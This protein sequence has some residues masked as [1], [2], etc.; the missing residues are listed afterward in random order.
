MKRNILLLLIML[1]LFAACEIKEFALPKWDV[2]VR[3]PL[4][5]QRFYVSELADEVNIIIS[6]DEVLTLVADGEMDTPEVGSVAL[7]PSVVLSDAPILSGDPA[8]MDLPIWDAAIDD[9]LYYGKIERGNFKYQ[10]NPIDPSA[11]ISLEFL[12][13]TDD[14]GENLRVELSG[15]SGWQNVNLAGYHFGDE[16]DNTE[17][18]NIEL[19]IVNSSDLPEGS[20]VATININLTEPL[21][22]SEFHGLLSDHELIM[23][24]SISA[25]ELQ[26]PLNIDQAVTL[27]VASLIID[28]ENRLGFRCEFEGEF[29]AIADG[30][31]DRIPIK[32]NNG[33]NFCIDPA[34]ADSP[35]ITRLVVENGL[36]NILQNMPTSIKL[37]NAKFTIST[38]GGLGFLHA[39]DYLSARYSIS[40][41]FTFILSDTPIT[42]NES[43]HLEISEDNQDIFNKRVSDS[44]MDFEIINRLPI[45]GRVEAYFSTIDEIDP[46]DPATF[47][48]AK[49]V[50]IKSSL[51]TNGGEP[52]FIPLELEEGE[53]R[54]FSNPEVFLKWRFAFE[55]SQ[56][57][58]I[59][60]Q[61]G[62]MD[63]IELRSMVS[64]KIMIGE[65]KK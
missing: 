32:D 27:Q 22:F 44:K 25:I 2:E 51:L 16:A 3:V 11:A 38:A 53:L 52:Q 8:N 34:E 57:Q 45:G 36:S 48:F 40:A 33:N 39:N 59:T 7:M 6:D 50:V 35:T 28:V 5:Y 21:Q 55:D 17:L 58:A 62:D 14:A 41:P 12:N 15:A 64:A 61:A 43:L 19:R 60:I 23:N 24:E 56:G 1:A 42:I 65:G 10:L 26:Y 31:E 37:D 9:I 4:I 47:D 30:V 29:V 63:F 20:I 49:S 13:I 54:L 46:D 18:E